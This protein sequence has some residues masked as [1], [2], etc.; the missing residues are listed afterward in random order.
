MQHHQRCHCLLF[1][2][3]NQC[4]SPAIHRNCTNL[5]IAHSTHQN[6][7]KQLDFAGVLFK[8]TDLWHDERLEIYSKRLIKSAFIIFNECPIHGKGMVFPFN[9]TNTTWKI[10]LILA[11]GAFSMG[12]AKYSIIQLMPIVLVKLR[13]TLLSENFHTPMGSSHCWL[14]AAV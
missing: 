5:F 11:L 14:Y 8:I 7:S 1:C 12:N 13:R 9:T 3:L 4:V 2:A 6:A 10:C